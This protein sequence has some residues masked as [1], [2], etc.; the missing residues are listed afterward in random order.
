MEMVQTLDDQLR[1]AAGPLA[2]SRVLLRAFRR[3]PKVGWLEWS[4]ELGRGPHR[5]RGNERRGGGAVMGSLIRNLR[6][7]ARTLWRSPTFTVATVLLVAL[8]V[9]TVTTVFT[10]VDH[11]LLRPLPY[12]AQDRLV[13]MTNGSHNGPTL[14]GLADVE[15]FE[16]WTAT[17]GDDVNL[18]LDG[19]DPLRLS[20]IEVTPSFFTIFGARPALGRLLVEED[21]ADRNIVVLTHESWTTIWGSDPDIIGTSIR[22]DGQPRVVVG[23]LSADFVV[24]ERLVGR[25]ASYFQPF[26]W[27]RPEFERA[28]YHAHNVVARLAP[29][30]SIEAADAQI[31]QLAARVA[32]QFPDY[33]SDG[34]HS[35]P[36]MSLRA[37]TVEDAQ[38]GLLMLLGAVGLLL[39]VACANI[40]HLFMARGLSRVREMA[41]RRALGAGIRILGGQLLVESL[42]VGLIGGALGI[43]I[44][45]GSLMGFA[46]WTDALPR[47]AAITLDFRV[48]AFAVLLA[49]GTALLFGMLPALRTIGRDL[50][51][52][53]RRAGP[54]ATGGRRT[55][56]IR[57]GLVVAEVGLSLVLVALAGL[58]LRSFLEVTR[59]DPG[60]DVEDVW[61]VPLNVAGIESPEDYRVRMD[62]VE[63]AVAKMPEVAVATYGI[64]APFEWTGGGSCCWSHRLTLPESGDRVGIHLH[65]ITPEFFATYGTELVAGG[66]WDEAD[67]DAEPTQVVINEELAIRLHGS[68][69]AAIGR[70]IEMN[71]RTWLIRGVAEPT[72]YYGL[73]RTHEGAFF[74]P[75]EILPFPIPR[76]VI[77]M[78]IPRVVIGMRVA[79]AGDGFG[80]RVREAIWSLEPELP[81]PEVLPLQTWVDDS[82]ATRRFGSVLLGSFGLIGLLLAAGGLYGTLLYAVGERRRELGIRLALGAGAARIQSQVVWSGIGMAILGVVVGGVGAWMLGRLMESFLFGVSAHD[83][84]AFA[85][86]AVVLLLTAGFASWLPA[87]R[88]A[89]T[90]PLETLKAD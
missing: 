84:I 30:V 19:A 4:E 88:A 63:D 48:L 16:L 22:I 46:R 59:Q 82:S 5:S 36:L 26:D 2:T 38:Q 18:T 11:V 55:R 51:D 71:E 54:G 32:A 62:A 13:Y 52:A 69:E 77:G 83:P 90:D 75:M 23:V 14:R 49:S 76:V 39:L 35:W 33:Y 1:D 73:D 47:G 6:F 17:G 85:G 29:G 27:D 80:R 64:E 87:N 21:Y 9:G 74:V 45:Q 40:A 31:D 12:P 20:A 79:N 53:M 44:A 68:A 41:I 67:A 61:V 72:L 57:G 65:P 34:A 3:L 86:A 15:G 78:R 7:A 58:L 37:R 28:G 24:P 66:V 70:E 50:A 56:V 81:I 10:V 60:F 42:T 43:G 89:R 8:G 25:R